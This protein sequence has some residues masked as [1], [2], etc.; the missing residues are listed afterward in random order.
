MTAHN[1]VAQKKIAIATLETKSMLSEWSAAAKA[2]SGSKDQTIALVK[3]IEATIDLI[4]AKNRLTKAEIENLKATTLS[5]L[6]YEESTK[7]L[8]KINASA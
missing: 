8:T 4:G 1:L 7:E 3:N 6:G 2:A 5:T